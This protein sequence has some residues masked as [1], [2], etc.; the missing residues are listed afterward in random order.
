MSDL[1]SQS[2]FRACRIDTG[3][4]VIQSVRMRLVSCRT[5]IDTSEVRYY[6]CVLCLLFSQTCPVCLEDFKMRS[7]VVVTP[8]R[9]GF[10]KMLVQI[11]YLSLKFH[12]SLSLSLSLSLILYSS[13]Q[14]PDWLPRNLSSLSLL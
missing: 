4:K 5:D 14:V 8:C 9:H 10:H 12:P 3:A 1:W 13:L 7:K 2:F 6:L 11:A